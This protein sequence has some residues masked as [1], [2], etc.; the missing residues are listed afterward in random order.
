LQA[1]Q[2]VGGTLRVGGGGEDGPPI[3]FQN[4]E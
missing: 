3:L 2:K 4:L 1:V